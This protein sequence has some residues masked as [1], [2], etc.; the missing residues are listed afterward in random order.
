[1]ANNPVIN[2]AVASPD[3]I[4]QVE[5]VARAL[6]GSLLDHG[7]SPSLVAAAGGAVVGIIAATHPAD[8]GAAFREGAKGWAEHVEGRMRAARSP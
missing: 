8:I 3:Q 6:A 7:W 2:I 1:M 5:T 4:D